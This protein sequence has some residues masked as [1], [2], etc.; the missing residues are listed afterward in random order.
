MIVIAIRNDTGPNVDR[1]A[2][3]HLQAPPSFLSIS[4]W[5]FT[6]GESLGTR[7]DADSKNLN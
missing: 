4:V 6:H 2:S 7:L 3:Y 1:L 5:S